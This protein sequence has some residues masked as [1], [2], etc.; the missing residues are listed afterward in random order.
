MA[1]KKEDTLEQRDVGKETFKMEIEVAPLKTKRFVFKESYADKKVVAQDKVCE[2]CACGSCRCEFPPPPDELDVDEDHCKSLDPHGA[3]QDAKMDTRQLKDLY[4]KFY[5]DLKEWNRFVAT[6]KVV[7]RKSKNE[8]YL[9]SNVQAV[10][11]A[12]EDVQRLTDFERF[13][14]LGILEELVDKLVILGANKPKVA[15]QLNFHLPKD[16]YTAKIRKRMYDADTN[17]LIAESQGQREVCRFSKLRTLAEHVVRITCDEIAE[18]STIDALQGFLS[19][20][21]RRVL[22]EKAIRSNYTDNLALIKV[23]KGLKSKN[24][25]D[26]KAV[27]EKYERMKKTLE[28]ELQHEMF[29]NG[30]YLSYFKDWA[31]AEFESE[32]WEKD[33]HY[34][35]WMEKELKKSEANVNTETR[36]HRDVVVFLKLAMRKL[37]KDTKR[38]SDKYDKDIEEKDT[39][40]ADVKQRRKDVHK[41][42]AEMLSV[43]E[44][45]QKAIQA[46]LRERTERER[47]AEETR[48]LNQAATKI[49]VRLEIIFSAESKLSISL[50]ISGS[51]VLS[52]HA[53]MALARSL[54][55]SM[56]LRVTVFP[57]RLSRYQGV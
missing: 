52:G 24:D 41:R 49:Q 9:F 3:D 12:A 17:L 43:F 45:R 57:M 29:R 48:K 15:P 8:T 39:E 23:L 25:K 10:E 19:L 33:E 18:R 16:R 31:D 32:K 47:R 38:W 4:L 54:I 11:G 21:E 36:V 42:M 46:Y 28:A 40:I 22:E 50:T 53:C 55:G 7:E 2:V 27:I 56:L 30:V 14:T 44:D 51:H 20:E 26:T 5:G 35:K 6:C 13:A 34:F 37:E 1:S